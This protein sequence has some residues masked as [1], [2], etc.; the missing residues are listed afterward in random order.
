MQTLISNPKLRGLAA[1][2]GALCISAFLASPALA[3][4]LIAYEV[5][6]KD[7]GL[8]SAGYS[9]RAQDASTAFTNP[10]GM[11]RLEGT[12][13]LAAGQL[14]W[15]NTKYSIDSGTSPEL[16]T[17][18]GGYLT[19]SDGW[20]VGGGAFVSYSATDKLSL[21]FALTGNFGAPL[22]YDDDWVGRYYVQDTTLIGISL[23]PSI[24]YQTTD[25]VSVS[26]GVTA[27][28]GYY[29]NQIAI[30]NVNPAF[31][32]GQLKFD[33]S[34]WGYGVNLGLLWDWTEDTRF[35]LTWNSQI[36]LDFKAGLEWS[37]LAPGIETVLG[38]AGLLN[39]SLKVGIKVPQQ[40]MAS[41]FTQVN[42]KWAIL[43]SLGWQE[44]SKF[45]L[46]QLGLDDSTNPSGVATDLN[47]KDTYHAALGAQYQL[48]N[49]WQLNFGVA[50]DSAFQSGN[51]SPLLAANAAWRFGF[52]AE[53]PLGEKSVWG[54]AT[55]YMYGGNLD[56]NTQSAVPV[57]AGGRGNLVGSYDNIST[58]FFSIY[59]NWQ[60]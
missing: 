52:G 37:G 17:G 26:F 14:L 36:D 2:F 20:F 18:D 53:R 12:Q 29:D 28:N 31:G 25:N 57:A 6:T 9:A 11:T 35:G 58:L 19:G 60:F 4:G 55:E 59:G 7:V 34:V 49:P 39:N 40:V 13:V 44:W 1:A 48:D 27:M 10:A 3:G 56:V 54:L 30:N 8:A 15:A 51:V 47:F 22:S 33:D 45:G 16:G 32:D 38:N 50:Y 24:A 42:D 23:I 43:G 41:T 5:G 21:G 46:L